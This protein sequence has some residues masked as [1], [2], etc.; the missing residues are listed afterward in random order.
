MHADASFMAHHDPMHHGKPKPCTLA[1]LL[2]SE[3]RIKDAVDRG[4]VHPFS[5]IRNRETA[6]RPRPK[7]RERCRT[8]CVKNHG[9]QSNLYSPRLI[10]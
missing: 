1:C 5:C 7:A 10:L 4:R 2:R 8:V 6:K 9:L 3:E